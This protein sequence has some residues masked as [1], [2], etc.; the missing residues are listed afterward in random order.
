MPKTN[1]CLTVRLY[2]KWR[3]Y[4]LRFKETSSASLSMEDGR[5]YQSHT[6]NRFKSSFY[7]FTA[8][9]PVP[10]HQYEESATPVMS[11]SLAFT[12]SPGLVSKYLDDCEADR[13]SSATTPLLVREL[14]EQITQ[15]TTRSMVASSSTSFISSPG[16]VGR[17]LDACEADRECDSPFEVSNNYQDSRASCLCPTPATGKRP[18]TFQYG[19][20]A[21]M[22]GKHF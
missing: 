22:R 8:M 13:R 12:S 14:H 1:Q 18:K 5:T 19:K 17:F 15:D 6:V 4:R 2:E 10:A 16:M 20:I 11:M 21:L 3:Q 7:T 9:T